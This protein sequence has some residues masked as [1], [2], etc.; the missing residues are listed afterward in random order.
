MEKDTLIAIGEALIDFIPA[1]TGCA[2]DKVTSFSPKCGG[3]PANVC[4]AFTVL[5]GKSRFITQLGDDPFGHKIAD[6][7]SSHNI[8]TSCIS[9]TDKANTALAFV[10]LEDDGNRTFSFYRKPSADMLFSAE[11]VEEKWF[12][13][14]YALHFCS[15][16]LGDFPMKDANRKAIAAAHEKGAIVSFDPNLRFPLWN[17]RNAL[18]D[19]VWEFIPTADILKISDEE[20][21]FITKESDIE[22]ALPKLF[23]GRVKLVIYTC[24]ADGAYAFTKNTKAFAASE[25]VKAADTTGAGDGFIGSFIYGLKELGVNADNIEKLDSSQLERC[26]EFSNRFCGESVQHA[27]AIDSY[28]KLDF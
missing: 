12:D 17:D 25:K 27:G 3:A 26:L 28:R 21:D 2:F 15:V 6:E 18:Y 14:A 11:Q 9:F 24:G 16:S 22:K 19:T 8:D 20:L 10:S 13:D 7:L 4:G 5:G 23:T 1:Q